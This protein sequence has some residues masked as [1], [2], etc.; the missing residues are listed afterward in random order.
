MVT[1]SSRHDGVER[2]VNALYF[3]SGA[4]RMPR[5]SSPADQVS[6]SSSSMQRPL[7]GETWLRAAAEGR[8]VGARMFRFLSVWG[9]RRADRMLE[10]DVE[11]LMRIDPRVQRE[12][13]LLRDRAE[14]EG[15]S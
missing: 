5:E 13:Q 10:R 12:F 1:V 2:M 8:G 6:S 9:R 15:R 3:F 11:V 4:I 7:A 14:W